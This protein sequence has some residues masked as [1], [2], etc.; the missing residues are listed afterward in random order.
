MK[1]LVYVFPTSEKSFKSFDR[2]FSIFLQ[3]CG[4]SYLSCWKEFSTLLEKELQAS[5]RHFGSS[6]K[7]MEETLEASGRSI[8]SF[9]FKLLNYLEEVS[10]SFWKKLLSSSRFLENLSMF[11]TQALQTFETSSPSFWD[12]FSKVLG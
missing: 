4:R 5:G 12:K 2:K 3:A 7:I 9:W 10:G 1:L 11:P 8:S 6:K